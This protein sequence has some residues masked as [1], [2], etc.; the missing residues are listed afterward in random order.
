MSLECHRI[1]ECRRLECDK[2]SKRY[3][4][5][6]QLP[7]AKIRK[8]EE[9]LYLKEIILKSQSWD[10]HGGNLSL[11][12]KEMPGLQT[13]SGSAGTWE[14]EPLGKHVLLAS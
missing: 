11:K 1:T 7:S 13:A 5:V 3:S 8:E 12:G 4:C 10:L 6:Q 2:S 14:E 9:I